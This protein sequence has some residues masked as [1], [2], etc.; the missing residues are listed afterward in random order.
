[1]RNPPHRP[2]PIQSQDVKP[3]AERSARFL[4][5]LLAALGSSATASDLVPKAAAAAVE[6]VGDWCAIWLWDQPAEELRLQGVHHRLPEKLPIVEQVAEGWITAAETH[7]RRQM[8]QLTQPVAKTISD[9]L[10]AAELF[11]SGER[12]NLAESAGAASILLAPL[13]LDG[14]TFGLLV[15]GSG[16][17]QTAS[18]KQDI[19]LAGEIAGQLS[20]AIAQLR[21]FEAATTDRRELE[22]QK[23][24]FLE[25]VSHELR[26]P[27]ASLKGSA[28]LLR[29]R[30]MS[31][32]RLSP[33][34]EELDM[35]EII[36]RQVG[37]LSRLVSDLM[38]FATV[39]MGRLELRRTKVSL[40]ALAKDLVAQMQVSAL[41]QEL[42]IE[43]RG[44]TIVDADPD[45]IEE[46]LSNLV[47]VAVKATGTTKTGKP[48]GRVD[49]AVRREGS[50]VVVS[51]R[52]YGMGISGEALAHVFDQPYLSRNHTRQAM[53]LGLYISKGM[54]EAHGGRMWL[55]SEEGKGTTFF[56]SLPAAG[57]ERLAG[58]QRGGKATEEA[59]G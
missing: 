59:E 53:G 52:D 34:Q 37:R 1:M 50:S 22:R 11:G 56:F 2:A 7:L 57:G 19:V 14:Q 18:R 35:L 31:K 23:D 24:E 46:V 8:G 51:V 48:P 6:A 40:G 33:N 47:S 4:A 27:L 21:R 28:Q 41:D 45:R 30:A 42:Q 12:A 32:S 16:D 36:D 54:I 17:P 38:E 26:T 44:E 5:Q 13:A 15:I 25:M 9:K 49:V 55:E 3:E 43:I 29:R 10:Q 20:S 39:Q 58:R